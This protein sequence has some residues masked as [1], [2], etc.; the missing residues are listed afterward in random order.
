MCTHAVMLSPELAVD[1]AGLLLKFYAQ[2]ETK[3]SSSSGDL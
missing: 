3:R 1:L 2:P